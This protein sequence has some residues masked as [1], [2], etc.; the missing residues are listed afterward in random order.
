MVAALNELTLDAEPSALEQL[1]IWL[2]AFIGMLPI[3]IE[4]RDTFVADLL[5]AVHEVAANQID[6]AYKQTDKKDGDC[7]PKISFSI[8]FE[9]AQ[10]A[11]VVRVQDHGQPL[12]VASI[13]RTTWRNTIDGEHL[14]AVEEPTWDQ[15]RGRGLFLIFS[16]TNKVV[17]RTAL[18][19][20]VWTL[21]KYI[22]P[23]Q[24]QQ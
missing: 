17:Y 9:P 4:S 10:R 16:L 22:K 12:D 14:D 20:N 3:S 6:H 5:L 24:P 21:T 13:A 1:P 18:G 7:T 8:E 19:G 11:V 23:H 15:E 2:Q